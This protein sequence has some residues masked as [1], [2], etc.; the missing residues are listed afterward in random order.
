MHSSLKKNTLI[1]IINP[2]NSK[3]VETKIFRKANYPKYLI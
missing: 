2:E 1:K 3:V